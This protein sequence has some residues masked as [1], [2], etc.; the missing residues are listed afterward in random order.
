MADRS[1]PVDFRKEA[2]DFFDVVQVIVVTILAA[3]FVVMAEK[4]KSIAASPLHH[5]HPLVQ[6]T[7]C[8]SY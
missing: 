6:V 4:K 2:K 8:I 7:T 3:M 5:I 1:K